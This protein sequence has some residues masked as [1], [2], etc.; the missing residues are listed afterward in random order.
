MIARS[1]IAVT[2]GLALAGCGGGRDAADTGNAA[3]E[4]ARAAHA[5]SDTGA[6]ATAATQGPLSAYV[7]RHPSEKV[8]GVAF[9]AQPTVRAAVAAAV[10][11]AK[12]R[13]FVFG[14]DG[15]D[16]PIVRKDG[17]ILAWGCEAHNCGFHNWSVA[18]TPDGSDAEV[19]FYRNDATADGP[20][21]WYVAGKTEQRP[22]N[23]PSE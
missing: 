18:I 3:A 7:G 1:A 8:A 10:P 4:T 20:S 19:C 14:Y 17:R 15:P 11:D 16:A 23:C 22:G 2:L 5:G 6:N 12:V 13:G 21:T 9:L